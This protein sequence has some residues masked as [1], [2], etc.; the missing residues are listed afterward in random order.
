M[1][2]AKILYLLNKLIKEI[3]SSKFQT[4]QLYNTVADLE[5]EK[6]KE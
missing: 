5:L 6:K 1:A 2:I 3:L 4:V